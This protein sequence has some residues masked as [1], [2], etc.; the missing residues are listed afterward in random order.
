MKMIKH[1]HYRGEAPVNNESDTW[2]PI[3]DRCGEPLTEPGAVVLS[4]PVNGQ[5]HKLHVC[6]SGCW[7]MLMEEIKD[8]VRLRIRFYE[9]VLDRCAPHLSR[10]VERCKHAPEGEVCCN[11]K[12]RGLWGTGCW[13]CH[14]AS[15]AVG[16]DDD[17]MQEA[18]YQ[19]G[20]HGDPE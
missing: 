4:P 17:A 13:C 15:Y 2:P 11:P 7:M 16:I 14:H 9:W 10:R 12:C 6:T 1:W 19:H 18:L 20:D 3:C 8:P 5:V